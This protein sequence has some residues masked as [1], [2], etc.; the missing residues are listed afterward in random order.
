MNLAL[1]DLDHTLL[2]LDSDHEWGEFFARSGYIDAAA[3]RA[4]NNEWFQHYLNGTLDPVAYLEFA[5]GNLA[6]FPRST[7]D[8]LR[9]EYV[10]TVIEPHILPAAKALVQKHLDAGDL[11]AI[12]TATNRFVT[13]PIAP[14]LG[15]QHLIAAE[16]EL[17][18]QGEFT[19]KLKGTPTHGA[20]KVTHTKAWLAGMGKSFDDFDHVY[21]YSDSPNDLPL[22]S[23]VSNPVATN[24]SDKLKQHAQD[25]GWPVIYL[26]DAESND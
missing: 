8:A 21:F 17:T 5:L 25:K 16:P 13:E 22:L 14:L 15:V 19:G 20:G 10:N 9:A 26:F 11:V 23:I 12:V 3:F 2:P 6:Q 18:E 7:L 4:K 1:F 24:P